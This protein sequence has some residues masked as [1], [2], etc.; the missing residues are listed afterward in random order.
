M[1]VRGFPE[2]MKGIGNVI[3]SEKKGIK[4]ARTKYNFKGILESKTKTVRITRGP[5]K[6]TAF[7]SVTA[8]K[9]METMERNLTLGSNR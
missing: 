3:I 2:T 9:I 5:H 1:K 6:N 7:S 8:Q 4:D